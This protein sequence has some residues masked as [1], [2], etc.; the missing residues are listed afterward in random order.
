MENIIK[1][2]HDKSFFKCVMVMQKLAD[3]I[4]KEKPKDENGREFQV[5]QIMDIGK[6][7]LI[8]E[9]LYNDN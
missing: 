3:V 2:T 9:L 5:L 6:G 8:V 4:F 7:K 1:K